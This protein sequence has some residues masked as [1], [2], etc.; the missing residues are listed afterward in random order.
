LPKPEYIYRIPRSTRYLYATLIN[1]PTLL[2]MIAAGVQMRSWLVGM[3]A[4]IPVLLTGLTLWLWSKAIIVIDAERIRW[5]LKRSELRWDDV[6][7]SE[8]V[9]QLG[10]EYAR[11]ET[12][13]GKVR[14]IVLNRV[15]GR[16]YR[17]H[18]LAKLGLT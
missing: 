11:V 8:I 3:G 12:K 17:A 14:R 15:G 1:L 18:V 2:F 10:T 13:R 7:T 9:R 4:I 5:P 16:E 6:S